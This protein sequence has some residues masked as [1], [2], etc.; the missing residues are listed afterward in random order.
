MTPA[1]I[2][3][4]RSNVL[5]GIFVTTVAGIASRF[6]ITAKFA[7]DASLIVDTAL[8]IVSLCGAAFA[9]YSRV[10]TPMP[11]VVRTKRQAEAINNPPKKLKR[12]K[13]AI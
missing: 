8:D 4:Y 1:A 7:P 3:W 10:H 6:H 5:R 11:K 12:K 13:G 2:P 9:A